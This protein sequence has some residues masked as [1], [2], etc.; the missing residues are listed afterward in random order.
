[1]ILNLIPCIPVNLLA[2]FSEEA[3]APDPR[4]KPPPAYAWV[5]FFWSATFYPLRREAF[6]LEMEALRWKWRVDRRDRQIQELIVEL[7]Q[8]ADEGAK[9]FKLF[10]AEKRRGIVLGARMAERISWNLLHSIWREGGDK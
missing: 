6:D 3:Y 7:Q 5:D 9:S 2:A 1:M 10:S 4:L 8:L